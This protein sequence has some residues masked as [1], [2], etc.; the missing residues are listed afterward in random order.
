MKLP[1]TEN[2]PMKIIPALLAIVS[3]S[4]GMFINLLSQE[5]LA[6]EQNRLPTLLLP[7]QGKYTGTN[8]SKAEANLGNYQ[9][10]AT[11]TNNGIEKP[12]A[13]G[14][15]IASTANT[16]SVET[17]NFEKGSLVSIRGE[18][19]S[20]DLKENGVYFDEYRFDGRS[21]E[22]FFIG[23]YSDAFAVGITIISPDGSTISPDSILFGGLIGITDTLPQNGTYTIKASYEEEEWNTGLYH[24]TVAL[25]EGSSKINELTQ[26]ASA[27]P[28]IGARSVADVEELSAIYAELISYF[29]LDS[30]ITVELTREVA[31]AYLIAGDA[32]TAEQYFLDFI[33]RQ[34]AQL[35]DVHPAVA[36]SLTTLGILYA[37]YRQESKAQ[38]LLYEAISINERLLGEDHPFVLLQKERVLISLG[39]NI[40]LD[41]SF[42]DNVARS[43]SIDPSDSETDLGLAARAA[44]M[45]VSSGKYEEALDSLYALIEDTSDNLLKSALLQSVAMVHTEQNNYHQ[46]AQALEESIELVERTRGEEFLSAGT[47]RDNP[48]EAITSSLFYSCIELAKSY[49]IIGEQDKAQ[50]IIEGLKQKV[51]PEYAQYYS[52]LLNPT[53]SIEAMLLQY[54][55]NYDEA[56]SILLKIL[57]FAESPP[58]SDPLAA[59][60]ANRLSGLYWAKGDLEKAV[61]FRNQAMSYEEN[62]IEFNLSLASDRQSVVFLRRL[63]ML[64]HA[65]IAFDTSEQTEGLDSERLGLS[66]VLQYKGRVLD[67]LSDRASMIRQQLSPENRGLYDELA[68]TRAQIASLTYQ[69]NQLQPTQVLEDELDELERKAERL[70]ADLVRKSVAFR[71]ETQTVSVDKA[72]EALPRNSALIEFVKYRSYDVNK[73]IAEAYGAPRY[74]AYILRS[75]GEIE[76]MDLGVASVIDQHIWDVRSVLQNKNVELKQVKDTID[77]LSSVLFSPLEQYVS[78][79]DHLLMAPDSELNLIPFEVLLSSSGRHLIQDFQITYLTSGRDLVRSSSEAEAKSPP[80][81]LADPLFGASGETVEPAEDDT[82]FGDISEY[83]FSALPYTAFEAREIKRLLPQSLLR[84]ESEANEAFLKQVNRPDILH[85]ATHGFFSSGR[86]ENPLLSSGLVLAGVEDSQSGI[87]EDGVFTALEAASLNL[88]GTQLVVLSACETG[89]GD[90]S[91]GEGLYGLRRALTIAGSESQ[92]V[93]LWQ[94]RDD[95]TKD[96]MVDYYEGLLQGEGRGQA[97]RRAQ[98]DMLSEES[99]AHPYYWAP[100]T[101]AGE[102]RPL[103]ELR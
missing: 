26:S 38:P 35:G 86:S 28:G 14:R 68:Q 66:S 85:I 54:Q 69:N 10:R 87:G 80:I 19:T 64:N 95:T 81:V 11:R 25:R 36:H 92:V 62:F 89:L 72:R 37:Q 70:E 57:E 99:T 4:P 24:L 90:V 53:D 76:S 88:L 79:L 103:D 44:I 50:N 6:S 71:T 32:G 46:A 98:L 9:A 33:E 77:R 91:A 83:S 48:F 41:D 40:S 18:V 55:G 58:I 5:A 56:E 42:D 102:W 74:A 12:F 16:K 49:V 23:V 29:G 7:F 17:I 96:L 100:F 51:P 21:G 15:S 45:L 59:E 20:S 67:I 65:T 93:S 8:T 31:L 94:V 101:I 30:P 73:P 61:Y 13:I 75:D 43:G 3:V 60:T 1:N 82:R 39:N 78:G 84:Q 97:L 63:E 22:P 34:R 2:Y 27:L 47:A 52:Q